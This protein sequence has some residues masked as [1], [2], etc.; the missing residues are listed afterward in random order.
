M[1]ERT[2]LADGARVCSQIDMEPLRAATVLVTGASGLIGTHVLASLCSL[3]QKGWNCT[4]IGVVKG[5]PPDH[6]EALRAAVPFELLRLDLSDPKT[7]DSLPRADVIVHAAGYAQPALF[8]ADPVATIQLNTTATAALIRRLLPDGRF[9]FV[10]SS[11]VYSGLDKQLLAESDIGTTSP[12][13]PRAAYI[14]GKRAGET[15]CHAARAQGISAAIGRLA[16][17]YGPGTR[18]HDS[19]VLN[20]FIEKALV[21]GRIELLDAGHAVRTYCYAA[22][23]VG[24]LWSILLRGRHAV[25]NVGGVA[26]VTVAELARRIG[27][28]TGADVVI[29]A[30]E[31]G[32]PG[33]PQEVRLDLSRVTS[34][35]T[36]WS[37]VSL[38]EGLCA[39]I[40]WQ[41]ALYAR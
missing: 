39:T 37:F 17:A 41:R 19:R 34:E 13:H 16:H 32:L 26:T 30:V 7:H 40:E 9:L 31:R 35:F 21:L 11:E 6:I 4:V 22:D 25:Y 10:S 1:L 36:A 3:Q 38:D 18:R 15:L 14:E 24:L 20:A 28:Y 5:D 23:A 12:D 29:P 2:L 27:H 8:T 33:A